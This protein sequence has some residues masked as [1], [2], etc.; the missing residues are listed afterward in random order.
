MSIWLRGLLLLRGWSVPE[1]EL[2]EV[3]SWLVENLAGSR[4]GSG[5][6]AGAMPCRGAVRFAIRGRADAGASDGLSAGGTIGRGAGIS[7]SLRA[8]LRWTSGRGTPT[9]GRRYSRGK[10][11]ERRYKAV[12]IDSDIAFTPGSGGLKMRRCAGVY[13]RNEVYREIMGWESFEPW[14]TRLETMPAETVWA[15]ANEVPPE[16]YGGDRARWKRWWRNC[17][18]GGAGSGS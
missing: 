14:L 11:R 1:T 2:V 16:W 10:Q 17:W 5:S 12:F 6:D 18:R 4:D 3:S 8:F 7:A 9:G 13:Y 15:A